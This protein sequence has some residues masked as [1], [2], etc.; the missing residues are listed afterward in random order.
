M[1]F[2]HTYIPD[3]ILLDVS[4]LTIR[5]YGFF[6]ALAVAT[7]LT[8][9]LYLAKKQNI[10]TDKIY[11]LLLWLTVGGIIGA[12]LYEVLVINWPYYYAD[13]S[14]IY[15]VWE[16]G[17][18]IHGAIIGGVISLWLWTK[19][20]KEKFWQMADL[21]AVVL[22]LG[23]A[24]GRWGNY[25]NGEL[26]GRPTDSL[27]GI[28]ID[29]SKRPERF[30]DYQYFQP[31]F[32]YESLLNLLLFF[33]L[34]FIAKYRDIRRGTLTMI[35]LAGYSAIRFVMEF[36]RIDPTPVYLGLR[37]P[38]VASLLIIFIVVILFFVRQHRLQVFD[39]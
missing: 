9:A 38:Q 30:L 5:W 31:T 35:Y 19:R 20:S 29:I 27:I 17:L 21:I 15:K 24:I 6:I 3:P 13:L 8:M 37:L 4:F 12:R 33:I 7:G 28:P 32:L 25:F 11:D 16:G 22:P 18:A 34:V 10:N 26:F 1:N 23:Q 36:I 2:L 14:A 39:R